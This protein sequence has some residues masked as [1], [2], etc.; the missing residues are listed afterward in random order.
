MLTAPGRIVLAGALAA[1]T[2][3]GPMRRRPG[4]A[5]NDIAVPGLATPIPALMMPS[6]AEVTRTPTARRTA[7]A[8]LRLL[9]STLDA[10]LA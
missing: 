9:R 7:W 2:L 8:A 5:W 10:D 6:P 4:P 3:L 1:R